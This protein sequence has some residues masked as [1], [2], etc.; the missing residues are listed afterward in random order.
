MHLLSGSFHSIECALKLSLLWLPYM[1]LF[2]YHQF[3]CHLVNLLTN[4]WFA[5]L[6]IAAVTFLVVHILEVNIHMC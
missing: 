5:I 4:M 3:N 2:D 6:N 1:L